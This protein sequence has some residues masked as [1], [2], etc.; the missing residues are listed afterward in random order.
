MPNG[1]H[2][3]RPLLVAV[4]QDEDGGTVVSDDQ[5]LVYGVGRDRACAVA[6]FL[7]S[8]GEFYELSRAASERGRTEDIAAFTL[9]SE[10]VE[11][12]KSPEVLSSQH[13]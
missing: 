5:F 7:V 11:P 1:L 12:L 4:E 10:Y 2:L 9:Q 6:D 13:S 8:L 3:R